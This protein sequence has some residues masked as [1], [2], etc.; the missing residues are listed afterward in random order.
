[1]HPVHGHADGCLW[2]NDPLLVMQ[3]FCRGD[4]DQAPSYDSSDSVCF[5]DGSALC[6]GVSRRWLDQQHT[7]MCRIE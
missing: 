2:R 5:E 6:D 1:M 4:A 3:G 7:R